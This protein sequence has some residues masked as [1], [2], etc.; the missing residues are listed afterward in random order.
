[1]THALPKYRVWDVETTTYELMKRKASPFDTRNWVVTHAW[2]RYDE[3]SVT[4]ERF[5]NERPP[6]GWFVKLLQG[7]T[8]LVG[9][10]IKFDLLH[11][12]YADRENLEAWMSFVSRGGMVW[13]CQLA[14]YLLNG[15]SQRD[16]MLSLD[17]VSVRYGGETKVDEVKVLWAA[18]VQT[19]DIE[20]ALLTRYLCGGPDENGHFAKGDIENTEVVFLGQLQRA[21]EADQV[22]SI[23]LNMG[24]LISTTEKERNGMFVDTAMGHEQAAELREEIT[25]LTAK[26]AT[27]LPDNLPFDFNWGSRYHKSA[28]IFGG[29]IKYPKREY[30]LGRDYGST[31]AGEYLFPEDFASQEDFFSFRAYANKTE[32]HYVLTDGTT[33]PT[34]PNGY[35]EGGDARY[36]KFATGKNAGTYK[37]KNVTVADYD[38]PKSRMGEDYFTFEGFAP[39]QKKWATSEPGVY[40]V[41]DEVIEELG[42]LHNV[43][44]LKDLARLT[45][46][47]K[48]L[49]TYYIA[50]DAQGRQK[51]M[52]S[53]VGPD[54]II[55]HKI[56]QTSTVT[57][58][59]S[60]SD[61]NLQ[62]VP[63]GNNSKVKSVFVSRF[64]PDGKIIQS[65]FTALEVY[66][67]AI[68]TGCKQLIDDLLAGLDMH[69]KRLATK[70]GISY[71]ECFKLCKGYTLEDGTKVP[72]EKEWDYKRT[73]AKVFSFQRAYGAGAAKIAA[74][75]GM[76]IEDVTALIEAEDLMYPEIGQFYEKLAATL[77]ATRKPIGR[78]IP[79]PEV[80]GVMCHIG[81]GVYR[82]PDNKLYLYTEHPAPEFAV[83]R[84]EFQNFSPTEIK[85]YVVQGEGGEW[86]KAADYIATREFYRRKNFDHRALLVNQVHDAQYADAAAEV[87]FEAAAL[88]HA[89]MEAASDYMEWRFDWPIPV[90]VPSDTTWGRS[91]ME[92]E[93]IPG[94]RDRAAELRL[95]IRRLQMGG[96]TP[97]FVH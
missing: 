83:K 13:D 80:R 91:M 59:F 43:P 56:N 41:T 77:K 25:G 44:F 95:D 90:P 85:N 16:H 15:M 34:P 94:V 61:P 17:E 2:K 93:P 51:G 74:S 73:G 70:E 72:P 50:T 88:L 65:D 78:V 6:Q 37:T 97:S 69:V 76:P 1:M 62:N 40:S 81:E 58:R 3:T 32:K 11:A 23:M 84:G 4:E 92:E 18:G 82:T 5:G 57:G 45:K 75:T 79:H 28:L 19:N 52:L 87:A 96:Y 36:A 55:H 49:G 24:A 47:S 54:G 20:P 9:F 86:A 67:Q 48:D 21:R 63:K 8:L 29:R 27:Y 35:I 64:G 14:E 60:S 68:L 7:I 89:S 10:N 38:K 12:I 66:I 42:V 31:P 22:N 30:L 71:E 46:L 39:P 53:L 26:L 33:T